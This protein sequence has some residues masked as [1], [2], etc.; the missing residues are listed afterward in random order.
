MPSK[1]IFV[2]FIFIL[3]IF[4]EKTDAISIV[5]CII[6]AKQIYLLT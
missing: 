1:V 4:F 5:F 2:T 3:F 6:D